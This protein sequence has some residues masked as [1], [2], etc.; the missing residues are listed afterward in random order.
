[1]LY[2]RTV[3]FISA[4]LSSLDRFFNRIYGSEYNPIYRTGTI[5]VVL[6]MMAIVSGL[7]LIF[8]YRVG[9]PYQSIVS[10]SEN[11][12]FT[13]WIRAF[14]RYASDAMVV[15][16]VLHALRMWA[17]KKSWG[18]RTFPWITGVILLLMTL[19]AAWSGFVMVWDT[20][21]LALISAFS[22]LIDRTG[23]LSSSLIQGFDGS[24]LKPEKSFFFF[25]AFLH[26]VIPLSMLFGIWAHTM[27]LARASWFPNKKLGLSILG[28]FIAISVVFSVPIGQEANLLERPAEYVLNAWYL[29]WMPW[30]QSHPALVLF[31][32]IGLTALLVLAPFLL[33]PRKKE[34]PPPSTLDK[35]VCNGCNQCVTD[36]PYEAISL[37]DRIQE[38]SEN[39]TGQSAKL[40]EK[41]AVVDT[42][43]CVSCALCTA[44]CPV[45]TIGPKGRTSIDQHKNANAFLKSAREKNTIKDEIIIVGCIKQPRSVSTLKRIENKY[46]NVSVFPIECMGTLHMRTIGQMTSQTGQI[47][48]AACP[49]RNCSNKDAHLLLR[50]RKEGLRIPSLPDR[51][52]KSK[53]H[54][55]PMGDG[56]EYKVEELIKKLSNISSSKRW[57]PN[58]LI[59][60]LF[61]FFMLAL[62]ALSSSVQLSAPESST[63]TLRLSWK[64][65]SQRLS[66]CH[67][68]TEDEQSSLRHMRLDQ[69]CSYIYPDY[70]LTVF[71][72]DEK[73]IDRTVS[74]SGRNKKSALHIFENL[75]LNPEDRKLRVVFAPESASLELNPDQAKSETELATLDQTFNI[76]I[77]KGKITLI[78]L[79][80]EK[81]LEVKYYHEANE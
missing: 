2:E 32:G 17:Q 79:N 19:L 41:H 10:I 16:V 59:S 7:I 71:L 15:A 14:H 40:S 39:D 36:C 64:L 62:L 38:D 4:L 24:S 42:S 35:D 20:Q 1:M 47:I 63:G 51:T 18:K 55:V 33:K 61:T 50:E 26:V 77:E 60:G 13:G 28:F 67:E 54:I 72:E 46:P 70:H 74:H 69:E 5:A 21:A 75:E 81:E 65:Q 53:V 29:F 57:F 56:E 48:L 31:L 27:K 34:I 76:H 3:K 73:V 25:V 68:A 66:F 23:I 52:D 11:W 37:V 78:H 22:D 49:E 30:A 80:K 43:L 9:S 8:F 58:W 6:L 45:F 12:W 44:S